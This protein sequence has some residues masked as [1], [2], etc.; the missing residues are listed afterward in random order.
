MNRCAVIDVGSN[1]MK[2][3][4]ADVGDDGSFAVAADTTRVS[5][6][7]ERL[8]RT[9]RLDGGAIDRNLDLLGVFLDTAREMGASPVAVVG[10]MALRSASNRVEFTSVARDRFGVNVE[11]LAGDEEARLSSAGAL[12]G[13]DLPPGKACLFDAGG[14]STEFIFVSAG[15]IERRYSLPVGVRRLTEEML[16]TDPVS[17]GELADL[18]SR[19]NRELGDPPGG[20]ATVVGIG[21]TVT[22]LASVMLGLEEYD[23][24]SIQGSLLPRDEA[25]RQVKLYAGATVEER[26]GI[27]GLLP[28]RADV[29]LAGVVIVSTIMGKLG[30]DSILVSDR[31]LRHGVLIDRFVRMRG[32]CG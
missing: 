19:V 4:V 14:G 27:V 11:I 12:S 5:R 18:V 17:P 9:G 25:D 8:H 7:G 6:L 20:A 21:G 16:K 30:A 13:L 28:A 24:A 2:L 23:P 15:E 26:K 1:S 3:L 10:T 31:G 29:I 22:S 32:G